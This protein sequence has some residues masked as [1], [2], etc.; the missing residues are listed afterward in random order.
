VL[1]SPDPSRSD[2][3]VIDLCFTVAGTELSFFSMISTIG[4]P[5]DVTA[6]ELR[7]E[8]FHPADD[9]TRSRWPEVAGDPTGELA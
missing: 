6:Q 4:T 8:C 3:P 7:I 2:G 9:S 1:A 5:I